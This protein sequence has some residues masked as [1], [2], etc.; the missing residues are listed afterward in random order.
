MKKIKSR[1]SIW[2]GLLAV[3]LLPVGARAAEHYNSGI[4]GLV[5]PPY[6]WNSIVVF[7]GRN[8]I[9]V[10]IAADGSFEVDLKPGRYVLTPNYAPG[11]GP[12]QPL[13]NLVARGNPITVRVTNH[14]FTLVEIPSGSPTIPK[15]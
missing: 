14:H 6:I 7:D 9:G 3:C 4:I 15:R 12:G 10:P 1:L 11:F 2:I 13:S 5:E 8:S